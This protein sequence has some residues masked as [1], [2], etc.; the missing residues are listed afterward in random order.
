MSAPVVRNDLQ[1]IEDVFRVPLIRRRGRAGSI[2][3]SNPTWNIHQRYLNKN[4]EVVIKK[5][6]Q[7]LSQEEREVLQSVLDDFTVEK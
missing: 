1:Y 5:I 2:F 3:V 4:Q 7:N 6:L